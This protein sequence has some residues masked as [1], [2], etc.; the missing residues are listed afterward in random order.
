MGALN[1]WNNQ[2]RSTYTYN[3]ANKIATETTE[4]WA[5]SN[6]MNTERETYTYDSN[7]HLTLVVTQLWD[8]D[9]SQWQDNSRLLY[10][11]NAFGDPVE[12]VYQIWNPEEFWRNEMRFTYNYLLGLGEVAQNAIG[13]FPNPASD[14][15]TIKSGL[16][17]SV[18]TYLI[19]D[20]HGRLVLTGNFNSPTT[21]IDVSTL[22]P[23][24]YFIRI[25]TSKTAAKLIKK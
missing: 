15:V 7:G 14:F 4:S 19:Y 3:A 21:T 17:V 11:N 8:F 10:T 12:I 5:Q 2:W 18:Q 16:I 22:A 24:Q 9:G 20:G 13:I 1:S 6:W 25:G 23:G